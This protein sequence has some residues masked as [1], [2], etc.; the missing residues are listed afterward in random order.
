MST[1]RLDS[2]RLVLADDHAVVRMGFRLLLEGAGATIVAEAADGP[3]A[4]D[5]YEFHRPDAMVMDVSMPG[6]GGLDALQRLILREPEARVL[7]LSAH[8]DAQIPLRALKAGACGYLS[9]SAHPEELLRAVQTISQGRRYVD[10]QLAAELA[11]AQVN[12]STD[13]L[14]QLTDKEFS[15]FLQLA[16][17]KSV[18][19]IARNIHVATSTVGTHL[20]HIKQKLSASNAAELTL[21][22]VRSGLIDA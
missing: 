7:M 22:A 5:A 9:K 8:E 13:P 17:G 21:I 16:Q 20:Y 1:P 10:P 4:V 11:L 18:N 15:I 2:L 12:G 3:A 14:S 19:D 6:G